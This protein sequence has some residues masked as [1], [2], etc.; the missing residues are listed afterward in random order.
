MNR[1]AVSIDQYAYVPIDVIDRFED[2]LV[3]VS[4]FGLA[5]SIVAA[6]L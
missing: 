2:S 1:P 3:S 6:L 5:V 4:S